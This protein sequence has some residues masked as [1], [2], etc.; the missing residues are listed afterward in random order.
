M[1]KGNRRVPSAVSERQVWRHFNWEKYV[2]I[3]KGVR[4]ELVACR[5]LQLTRVMLCFRNEAQEDIRG[6]V[7]VE[8]FLWG[9]DIVIVVSGLASI[10]KSIS[11]L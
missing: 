11:R 10:S 8:I 2:A 7:Y 6:T 3:I 5:V 9:H 1:V 4:N